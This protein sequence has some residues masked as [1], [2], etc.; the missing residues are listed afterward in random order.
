MKQI[1]RNEQNLKVILLLQKL[2]V[3]AYITLTFPYKCPFKQTK[4]L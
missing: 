3:F 1:N 4:Q 2:V